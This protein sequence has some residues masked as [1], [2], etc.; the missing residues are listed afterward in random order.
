MKK[1]SKIY[2]AGHTGLIG[3]AIYRNLKDLSCSKIITRTHKQLDL[4]CKN[5]VER[6]FSREKPEYIF[7]SAAKVGGIHANKSYPAEFI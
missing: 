4:T 3:S 5:K 1:T 2:I 6:F 7:M